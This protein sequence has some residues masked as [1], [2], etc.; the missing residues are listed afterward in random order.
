M[1]LYLLQTSLCMFVPSVLL[2]P[3]ASFGTK[4]NSADY[5]WQPNVKGSRGKDIRGRKG[6]RTMNS[7]KFLPGRRRLFKSGRRKGIVQ[8]KGRS[9]CKQPFKRRRAHN[10]KWQME[11]RENCG[12]GGEVRIGM[13]ATTLT[14]T[15]VSGDADI[16]ISFDRFRVHTIINILT[17]RN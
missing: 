13:A 2:Q 7:K 3:I 4:N 6:E 16:D 5:K 17:S 10:T 14:F 8:E 12:R 1:N 9:L 15:E 11:P